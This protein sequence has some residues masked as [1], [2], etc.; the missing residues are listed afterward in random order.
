[1]GEQAQTDT[2]LRQLTRKIQEGLSEIQISKAREPRRIIFLTG[3]K[4]YNILTLE[5]VDEGDY[6]DKS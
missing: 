1:M 2:E 3:D 4:G 5:W 6:A